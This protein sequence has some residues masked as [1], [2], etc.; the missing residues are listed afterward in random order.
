MPRWLTRVVVGIIYHPAHANNRRMTDHILNTVDHILSR[1]HPNSGV[2][3]VGDF[4]RLPDG[5]LRNYPLSLR[6]VVRGST[7]KALYWIRSTLTCQNGTSY[8]L[9][10]RR[11]DHQ[12]TE[13][14]RSWC[15]V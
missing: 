15:A 3:V 11:S 1:A 4:N 13:Q 5:Q 10:Y 7:R 14:N 8:R 12:T 2:A 6:H 9:S